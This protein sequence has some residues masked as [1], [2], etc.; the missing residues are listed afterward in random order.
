MCRDWIDQGDNRPSGI[1]CHDG[2]FHTGCTMRFAAA[3][4]SGILQEGCDGL[5]R[6]AIHSFGYM[7]V[8]VKR[9]R[10]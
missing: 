9:C 7:G 1:E 8:L 5:S 4:L 3:D 6:F 10:Y 2:F